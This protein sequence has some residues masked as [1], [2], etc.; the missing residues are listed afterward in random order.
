M[1]HLKHKYDQNKKHHLNNNKNLK[2][3]LDDSLSSND[4]NPH[5]ISVT[6]NSMP[7]NEIIIILKN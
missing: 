6:E 1:G 2:L 5:F 4:L 3:N 7:S